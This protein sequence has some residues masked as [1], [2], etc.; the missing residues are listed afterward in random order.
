MSKQRDSIAQKMGE[1]G[2]AYAVTTKKTILPNDGFGASSKYHVHPDA[3]YPHENAIQRFDTLA[4]VEAYLDAAIKA[5]AAPGQAQEIWQDY[6]DM[7]DWHAQ[8]ARR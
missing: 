7:A 8:R 4:E 6:Q 3:S 2:A 5:Q 1:V